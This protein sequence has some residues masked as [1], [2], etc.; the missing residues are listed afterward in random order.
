MRTST[1]G[2]PDSCADGLPQSAGIPTAD[3]RACERAAEPVFGACRAGAQ[4]GHVVGVS[5][6]LVT[7][8]CRRP[9]DHQTARS[10]QLLVSKT[11]WCAKTRARSNRRL[12][13]ERLQAEHKHCPCAHARQG[14][15]TGIRLSPRGHTAR[16][17][18]THSRGNFVARQSRLGSAGSQACLRA[19]LKVPWVP[20]AITG[21]RHAAQT[22]S[23]RTASRPLEVMSTP[24]C[25][26]AWA[27]S[28][29]D[30]PHKG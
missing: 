25:G 12:R 4:A 6:A 22:S 19:E 9:V 10:R 28:R 23:M 17:A 15:S 14:Q 21:Y 26:A 11:A 29:A 27:R 8:C 3:S 20:Y 13:G 24:T 7:D 30:V 18:A 5:P 16:W 2:Q 1:R